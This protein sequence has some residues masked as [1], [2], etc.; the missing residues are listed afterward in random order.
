MII[1][2]KVSIILPI[3]NEEVYLEQ[4]LNSI[5]N[6]TLR[7]I[8]IICVDDG[9]TDHSL[10]ILKEYAQK[11]SRI[12]VFRQENQFAG[13]ARNNGMRYANG[14]YLLFL[15]S[16]DFFELDMIEKLYNRAEKDNL[17]IVLCRYNFF[18]NAEG[19]IV[20]KDFTYDNSFLCE[21]DVFEGTDL[22]HSAI[23]QLTNGWAW[24]KLFRAEFVREQRYHFS[25][26]RSSE[27]GF[28]VYMLFAKAK[29]IGYLD[30]RLIHQRINNK[31]SLSN[32]L[33]K[34]WINGFRMLNLIKEEMERCGIYSLYQSSFF[35]FVLSFVKW[36]M[37]AMNTTEAVKKSYS[38][39]K[40]ELEPE[41]KIMKYP[42]EKILHPN[43]MEWYEKVNKYSLEEYL[44]LELKNRDKII[45]E[46][47]KNHNQ[48]VKER[49]WVFPYKVI[50][51]DKIVVLYGAGEIGKC[52]Y[53]QLNGSGYCRK[54][55][56][57]DSRYEKFINT[58]LDVQN[59]D[60]VL[61]EELD[62]II[63][64]IKNEK[65]QIEI[66]KNLEEKGIATEKV[67]FYGKM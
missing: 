67:R 31:V 33:D 48:L 13:V 14:Q 59:P 23:F 50:E 28:F 4:C 61:E 26:F 64:A 30:E 40:Q 7:D 17:D 6:Q 20:E 38:Y 3:Y 42:R 66:E 37:G 12:R 9:S 43:L 18:D 53:E 25:E 63:V 10:D 24:D 32:T 46:Y 51:K 21:K 41:Y 35:T 29:K 16:D 34:N 56:W 19:K 39:I 5:C 36:Y 58:E 65:V 52:Y 8:E 1:V 2:P 44:F 62:Y 49:K 15:D 11:D 45:Q 55:I 54:L 47:A 57:I 27:D 22:K 60:E